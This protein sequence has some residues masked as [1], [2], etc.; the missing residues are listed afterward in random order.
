[1]RE[2]ENMR[3]VAA[4]LPDYMGFIFYERSKRFV[5]KEFEIPKG[6][7]NSIKRVGVFVNENWDALLQKVADYRLDFVQLHGSETMDECKSIK[8]KGVRVIKVFQVDG[9]FDFDQTKLFESCVEN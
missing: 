7:P 3:E 2:H 8:G 9:D 4:L 6:F 1:M 5:G